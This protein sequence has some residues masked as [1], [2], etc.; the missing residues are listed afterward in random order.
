MCAQLLREAQQKREQRAEMDGER[1]R[2]LDLSRARES[3][4]SEELEKLQRLMLMEKEGRL[5]CGLLGVST[6]LGVHH[7]QGSLGQR[8]DYQE[9]HIHH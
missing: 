5:V 2:D 8:V 3:V 7:S 6:I 4:L 1:N 9:H